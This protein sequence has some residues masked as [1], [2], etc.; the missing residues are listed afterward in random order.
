MKKIER[1]IVSVFDKNNVIKF[2]RSLTKF[3]IKILST[4]GTGRLLNE[5][6]I[7]FEK[8]SDYTGSPEMFD[9]KL[10]EEYSF[11]VNLTEIM[12]TL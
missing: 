1:A 11:V 6:G 5:N 3:G 2:V 4:G 8:I 12:T 7:D 9:G 10:K